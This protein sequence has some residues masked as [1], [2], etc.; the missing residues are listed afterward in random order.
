[1]SGSSSVTARAKGLHTFV[2]PLSDSI[3]QGSFADVSNVVV[4]R[5]GIIEPRRGFNQYHNSFGSST[6]RAKQLLNYKDSV[7]RHVLNELQ[8]DYGNE[9]LSFSGDSITEVR[10]GLRIR[11]IEANG[12]LYFVTATGVKKISARSAADFPNISITNAGGVKALDVIAKPDYTSQGFLTPNSKVAYEVVWGIKDLNENLILGTPSSRTIVSNL[13]LTSSC[14]V[15]LQ[16]AIPEEVTSTNYFYQVY[17]TAVFQGAIKD[18][19]GALATE[20]PID[21][22]QE[23]YLV[24]ESVITSAELSAGIVGTITPLNDITPEDYRKS[25]TLLYTNPVSGNGLDQANEKPP[26]A[27]DIALYKNYT[28]YANTK[29]VQRMN[30]GFLSVS[31]LAGGSIS[32]SDGTSTNTYAFQ[33]DIETYNLNFIG[34]TNADF[35]NSIAGPAKYFTL[36]SASDETKYLIYYHASDNDQ[37]PTLNGALAVKVEVVPSNITEVQRLIFSTV[38]T[39]GA[40]KLTYGALTTASLAFNADATAVQTALQALTGLSSVTVTGTYTA[41]FDVTFTGVVGDATLIGITDNT[42]VDSASA[43]VTLIASTLTAGVAADTLAQII[44]NTVNAILD[45]SKDFNISYSPTAMSIACAN[46]GFVAVAP[47]TT[48]ASPFTITADGNGKGQDVVNNKI[49]LPR[50]PTTGAPNGPSPSQQLE[51]VARSLISV[52]NQ[53]DTI[54]YAY[55]DS[56]YDEVPG[57]I[58]F[59]Q[60][61]VTGPQFYFTASLGAGSQFT[62]ALPVSGTAVISSNEV[63]PNRV[64]YSKL[65]QPEAVPL[66]NYI[67]IGPKDR[68]IK[69][70]IAL[71]DSLFVFKENGI[72]RISGETAP[73]VVQEFDFSSQ[74]LASDSATILNNQI[75][76]L[77]TQ[78]V[79]KVSDTGVDIISRPIENLIL[80][81]LR[82][83]YDYKNLSFG[84]GYETDRAYLLF[85]P[86]NPSDTVATQCLRFNIFTNTWTKWDV[87]AT[88]GLVNFADET[89]YI[90]AGDINYVEKERKTLTRMDHADRE[91]SLTILTDGVDQN[92]VKLASITN[93]A[94][95]DAIIQRQYLT[96]SQFNRLLKKL[97]DD[98]T[99][100]D[101]DY[102]SA[103]TFIAGKNIRT[104]LINLASK[105]DLDSGIVASNFL[106]KIDNY[107]YNVSSVVVN[108]GQTTINLTAPSHKILASRWIETN[109]SS[110]IYQVVSVGATSITINGILTTTPTI[111]QTASDSFID[112][113]ACYNIIVDILNNDLGAFFTNYPI[114][115]GYID[116]ESLVLGLDK[117]NRKI[118]IKTSMD[119]LA[120]PITLYKSIHSSVIWNPIYFQDPSLLKQVREGTMIFENSNFSSVTISYATDLSPAFEGI[121]FSGEGLGV[122]DWGYF[123]FG[124]INWGGIA[125][126]IPLRTLIPLEKQRCRFMNV[127]FEHSVAFEKYS[128]YGLSLVFRSISTRGYR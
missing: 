35:R 104:S 115:T 33:G 5:D 63:S 67:D 57:K 31:Q 47:T 102:E 1:M 110:N 113:Q 20:E 22:G 34:M 42:L 19:D 26:F 87:S 58:R 128:I 56:A 12:N 65:Q 106:E 48:L 45:A 66:S 28:F 38:Q 61:D 41:G 49:F 117:T 75:Y 120:G 127:Q 25:G 32:I 55:Y 94:I 8:F 86:S 51:Q 84:V 98:V 4:D 16:F 17:R 123:N 82:N 119:L 13:S 62:P 30:L 6:D 52:I 103:L 64:Y 95:N 88:C 109:L 68:E 21:P 100:V 122:G 99:V 97:D 118:T 78:G 105:L 73:F 124:S 29:T 7:L 15:S 27:A 107:L 11:S 126:P 36:T 50:I 90:G 116:F 44:E 23:F 93:V 37:V 77:S 14:I 39:S 69:R 10:S 53:Q 112:N 92:V 79:I 81:I 54:A 60:Q 2:N 83:Q 80:K 40:Y 46:N 108:G 91:Y 72:Y 111:V 70:I 89:L 125:A 76:A 85:L 3:P 71:R 74:V 101:T 114:S 9:F 121:T 59:E 18:I 96:G 24:F 43:S